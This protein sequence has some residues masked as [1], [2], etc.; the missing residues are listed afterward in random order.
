MNNSY[1]SFWQANDALAK[2]MS[3]QKPDAVQAMSQ[4]D[5]AALCRSEA[6]AVASLLKSDSVSFRNLLNERI[7][8]VKSQQQ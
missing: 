5:R 4:S 2:C 3:A 6:D 8:A 1:V 7:A